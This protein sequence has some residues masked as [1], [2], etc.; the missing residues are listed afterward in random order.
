MSYFPMAEKDEQDGGW[1]L[2]VAFLKAVQGAAMTHG[3][4][5][6]LEDVE[7]VLLA[8]EAH[9]ILGVDVLREEL[10]QWQNAAGSH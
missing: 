10:A 4:D 8:A 7:S 5:V 6:S 3:G 2:S 1:V 9:A